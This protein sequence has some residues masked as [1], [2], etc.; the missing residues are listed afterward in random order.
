MPSTDELEKKICFEKKLWVLFHKLQNWLENF[1]WSV[2]TIT[3]SQSLDKTII[4]GTF[5][6]YRIQSNS[7]FRLSILLLLQWYYSY[8]L[9]Q[10]NTYFSVKINFQ[11]FSV[12]SISRKFSWKWL[13]R[14]I[15]SYQTIPHNYNTTGNYYSQHSDRI[16]SDINHSNTGHRNR[17][18][19][20]INETEPFLS[21]RSE[22][23]EEAIFIN[24]NL[25]LVGTLKSTFIDWIKIINCKQ[26]VCFGL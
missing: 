7:A 12:K 22:D 5:F 8:F 20:V 13:S 23:N 17:Q 11:K 6:R 3:S 26:L 1:S 9:M 19:L 18:K 14:K 10:K 16:Y 4:L 2:I 25:E 15:I 21:S 24:K